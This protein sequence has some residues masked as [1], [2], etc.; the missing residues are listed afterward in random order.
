ME[1][2]EE[3]LHAGISDVLCSIYRP[4]R[5]D[6]LGFYLG[7]DGQAGVKG[8]GREKIGLKGAVS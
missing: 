1:G 8:R 6:H 4:D 3:P 5:C 2:K 7:R